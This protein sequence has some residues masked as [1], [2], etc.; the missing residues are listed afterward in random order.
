MSR[1][2]KKNWGYSIALSC[3]SKKK[4]KAIFHRIYRAHERD[5][6]NL[7]KFDLIGGKML[8]HQRRWTWECEAIL[9]STKQDYS[10]ETICQKLR[11]EAACHSRYCHSG[12]CNDESCWVCRFCK[13]S[14]CT[15]ENFES[16]L[17]HE[18]LARFRAYIVAK[19]FGK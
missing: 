3:C 6:I 15:P 11:T 5:C 14:G 1:S 17:T 12:Y 2:R 7:G 8:N 4:D 10:I 16:N 9:Y 18:N 13:M 19:Y